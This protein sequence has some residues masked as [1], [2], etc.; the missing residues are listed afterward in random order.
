MQ[1]E[2]PDMKVDDYHAHPAWGSSALKSLARGEDL[3]RWYQTYVK[4]ERDDDSDARRMGRAFHSAMEKP[5]GWRDGYIVI[6]EKVGDDEFVESINRE[7]K[8]SES[9]A[10]PLVPKKPINRQM[11]AH[12]SY[13]EAWQNKAKRENKEFVTA[14]ELDTIYRMV[15]AVF[16]NPAFEREGI[17]RSGN[18]VERP[19]I[20]QCPETGLWLKSLLDLCNRQSDRFFVD[21]KKTGQRTPRSFVRDADRFGYPHQIDYYG[22]VTDIDRHYL[23]YVTDSEPFEAHL[24]ELKREQLRQHR[25]DNLRALERIKQLMEQAKDCD[26]DS[27]GVPTIFHN[28]LWGSCWDLSAFDDDSVEWDI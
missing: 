22:Y 8:E 27:Q 23:A 6:P 12:R 10:Q 25:D 19:C 21:W 5:D 11:P 1:R 17:F 2:W 13:I 14:A 16:D 4:R 3:L 20:A 18:E 24:I 26:T 9:K 28:E 15:A 7:L